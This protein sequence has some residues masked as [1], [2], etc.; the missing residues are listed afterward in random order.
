MNT[1]SKAPRNGTA[2]LTLLALI[3]SLGCAAGAAHAGGISAASEPAVNVRY[4]DLNLDTRAGVEALYSR[5]VSAAALV[6]GSPD[7]RDLARF[8]M[9]HSCQRQAVARAVHDVHNEKLTALDRPALN[10]G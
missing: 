2:P 5:I 10:H 1:V 4:D 3:A 6:C 7:I 9:S 8:Q